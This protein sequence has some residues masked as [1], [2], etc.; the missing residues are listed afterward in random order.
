MGNRV[1]LGES[2]RIGKRQGVAGQTT[3]RP[4]SGGRFAV[5]YRLPAKDTASGR[6]RNERR[7]RGIAIGRGVDAAARF[8]SP[9]VIAAAST[10][11]KPCVQVFPH[12]LWE[13]IPSVFDGGRPS[14]ADGAIGV[15]E[16][17][18][19][20]GKR[21]QPAGDSPWTSFRNASLSLRVIGPGLPSP[22]SRPSSRTAGITSA[23]L[24]VKKHS[25]ATNR[26]CRVRAV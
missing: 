11:F 10:R 2:G 17:A 1:R 26:S 12:D 21:R 16:S 15:P 3:G 5:V 13:E 18:L 24:P 6:S 9:G 20:L 14:L 8:L 23:A 22:M 4:D 19:H 7:R 25:S